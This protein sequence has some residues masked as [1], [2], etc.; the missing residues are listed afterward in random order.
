M[1]AQVSSL[2]RLPAGGNNRVYKLH[3]EG[4]DPL[5]AKVYYQHLNDPRNRLNAEYRAL[6]FLWAEG[7]RAVP[8]PFLAK[9]EMGF[10]VYEFIVGKKIIQGTET[11]AQ[12][13]AAAEFL[14]G[15]RDLSSSPNAQG[16]GAASEACF[17]FL[18]LIENVKSRLDRLEGIQSDEDDLAL[19]MATFLRKDFRAEL[20]EHSELGVQ[21]LSEGG[22]DP[23]RPLAPEFRTLSPSDF[24][25]HNALVRPSGDIAFLD[26]E[27]FGWDDPVKMVS[28]FLL[29]PGMNLGVGQQDQFWNELS[30]VLSQDEHFETRF[31]SY[32]PMLGLKW[33]LILLNE[34]LPDQFGRRKF[35]SEDKLDPDR[36][37]REQLKKARQMLERLMKECEDFPYVRT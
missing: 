14:I 29:H 18:E 19:E 36:A 31:R 33:C 30:P 28:D 6:E 27:Y 22:I 4:R 17:S 9:P 5:V 35:A 10:A 21:R 37:R 7:I 26:F 1:G 8:K 34:F 32:Y 25:F 20:E 13:R 23:T 12:I 2:E 11:S 24:G 16:L 15:L 3:F